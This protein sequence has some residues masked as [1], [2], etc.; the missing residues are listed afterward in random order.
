M[1]PSHE[2]RL[3]VGNIAST[4]LTSASCVERCRKDFRCCVVAQLGSPWVPWL[5]RARLRKWT[6]CL[7]L[8][9]STAVPAVGWPVAS[10]VVRRQDRFKKVKELGSG[11]YGTVYKLESMCGSGTD[12]F[13]S[14][15]Y[16][17]CH[18]GD[19]MG[20]PGLNSIIKFTQFYVVSRF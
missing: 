7:K 1:G 13:V 17:D 19:V 12:K 15:K 6:S 3:G 14:M 11:A 20:H 18:N 8:G 16:Q 10:V 9:R 2:P 4:C 5:T